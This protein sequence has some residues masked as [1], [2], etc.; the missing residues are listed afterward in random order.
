[1]IA[2]YGICAHGADGPLMF[3]Q[4]Y[5]F[6]EQPFGFTP[7][8]RFLFP[9]ESCREAHASLLYAITNNVGF[10]TLIA[11]PGM[12]KTTLLFSV[13]ERFRDTARTAFVFTTQDSFRDLLRYINLEFDLPDCG[14]DPVT[15]QQQFK[16]F[17][18]AEAH[19]ESPVILLLDEAQ[20]LND[21]SLE[22]IRLLSDFETPGQKL[23]HIILA[24][25][26]QFAERLR[27]S[28]MSQ[29]FQRMATV[30]RLAKLTHAE[31]AAYVEHHLRTA[32]YRGD[33]LFTPDALAWIAEK[34]DGIP[35]QINRLCF[36]GLSIGCGLQKQYVDLDILREVEQ[37]LD[38]HAMSDSKTHVASQDFGMP[39][40][41]LRRR[42][43]LCPPPGHQSVGSYSTAN[44]MKGSRVFHRPPR[45]PDAAS[46]RSNHANPVLEEL[47]PISAIT[48]P[49]FI[50]EKPSKLGSRALKITVAALVLIEIAAAIVLVERGDPAT[51]Q[52][53]DRVRE[54]LRTIVTDRNTST[55]Y[56]LHQQG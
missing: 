22:A 33:K 40:H 36:N 38:L 28:G 6:R 25:Q 48:P 5:G 16:E 13:L 10:S 17:L 54:E 41:P 7:N 4:Y 15:F 23:L 9:S 8:P 39:R 49:N 47:P 12:G 30:S 32:G 50:A 34:A 18:V 56:Y 46:V 53:I 55:T 2:A 19:R 26:P 35:R 20:N 45:E 37:D 21:A 3:L 44:P 51:L 24:G 14:N 27:Q 42:T 43:D 29:L 11:D 31:T 52:I 1:V